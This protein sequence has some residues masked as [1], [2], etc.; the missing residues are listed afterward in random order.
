MELWR[1]FRV[2]ALL[3]LAIGP[4]SLYIF[5]LAASQGFFSAA[6]PAV[7]A[8]TLVDLLFVLAAILG[9]GAWIR[10]RPKVRTGLKWF[11]GIVLI[12]F[13][14]FTILDAFGISLLPGLSLTG[15][16]SSMPGWLY[17]ALLTL[18]SPLTIVFWAGV[19]STQLAK[20]Q[21][22]MG[23]QFQFGV[24]AV[25]ATPLFQSLIAL[26]G[27]L[28]HAFLPAPATQIL[29]AVVGGVLLALGVRSLLQKSAPETGA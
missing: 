23:A 26:L 5:R 28:T 4:I 19:F 21:L 16:Q 20:R 29:T 3:Q 14:A 6:L 24:G 11:G 1:G 7:L 17:A 22:S 13:G 9:L 10:N 27:S 18:S 25:L 8:V 15:D 2:G 12:L